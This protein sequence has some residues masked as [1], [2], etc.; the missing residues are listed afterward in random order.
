VFVWNRQAGTTERVSLDSPDGQANDASTDPAIS[1]DGS[2]VAFFSA[3]SNLV[4]GDTT[5]ATSPRCRSAAATA[6]AS[7]PTPDDPA[8]ASR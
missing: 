2:V 3:T 5:P 7:S 8:G 4:A 1:G 6:P